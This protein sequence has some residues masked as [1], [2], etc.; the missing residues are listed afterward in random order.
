MEQSY[1]PLTLES[2]RIPLLKKVEL[3]FSNRDAPVSEVGINVS[4]TGLF[5]RSSAPQPEG[6]L[7]SFRFRIHEEGEPI[8]G[9]AEVVWVRE[10]E[11][12]AYKPAGMG[13]RFLR[14]DGDGR[15]HLRGAVQRMIAE[16]EAPP[17]LRDLRSV[18]E[19][20]L[21]GILG[22]ETEEAPQPVRRSAP[23][24]FR[25]SESRTVVSRRAE[26]PLWRRLVWL[27]LVLL[28]VAGGAFLGWKALDD[29]T[30]GSLGGWLASLTDKAS[31]E[32]ATATGAAGNAGGEAAARVSEPQSQPEAQQEPRQ[33]TRQG[34]DDPSSEA[35]D[36]SGE[37]ETGEAET[38]VAST[39]E[40]A[41][42]PDRAEISIDE[43]L[44]AGAEEVV[45]SWAAAWSEQ[46]VEDYLSFYSADFRPA[47]G[48]SRSSWEAQ[49]RQRVR[50]PKTLNILVQDLETTLVPPDGA[51]VQF[52]Q[53]YRSDTFRDT[54]LKTL[55]LSLENGRWKIVEE[56]VDT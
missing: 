16:T 13:M 55:S 37:T 26:M 43:E 9:L 20:T 34:A 33:A 38:A 51:W 15:K 12:G 41:A 7:A 3:R 18:V 46:R 35:E 21:E 19:E 42:L 44:L 36:P 8:E 22:I 27:P 53:S 28:L 14:V 17:E 10:E 50:A 32:P 2:R 40:E 49:R 6:S 30:P 29:P 24:N 54:V 1:P 23:P 56:R 47:D 52:Q 39:D 45:V 25:S 48:S 5:V 4:M 31:R 11:E